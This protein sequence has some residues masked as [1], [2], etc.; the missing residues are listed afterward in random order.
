MARFQDE[1]GL[2]PKVQMA[3]SGSAT[4]AG[5]RPGKWTVTARD[6]RGQGEEVEREVEVVEGETASLSIHLE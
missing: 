4:L 1:E 5:L 3:Q 2:E 6:V